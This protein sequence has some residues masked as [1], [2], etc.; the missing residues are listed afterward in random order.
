MEHVFVDTAAW[1]A[2]LNTSDRLHGQAQRVMS[3]LQQQRIHLV[4][5]EFVLLEVADSLAAPPVRAKTITFI[6]GLRQLPILR[7]VP[8][9]QRLLADA[10]TL[11]GQRADKGWGWTDCTSFVVMAQEQ[12]VRAFTSD[13]HFEQAGFTVLMSPS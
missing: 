3:E 13:H 10:W 5:T 11:Y 9:Q 8:A 1:I 2:L 12:I 4:T 6:D 7:T